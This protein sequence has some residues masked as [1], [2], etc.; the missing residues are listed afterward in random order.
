MPKADILLKRKVSETNFGEAVQE[1]SQLGNTNKL[2][3]LLKAR[4]IEDTEV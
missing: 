2:G 3:A 4:Y 1:L